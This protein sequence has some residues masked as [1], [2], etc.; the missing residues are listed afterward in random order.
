[1]SGPVPVGA[2]GGLG[3]KAYRPRL[4]LESCWSELVT[5][6]SVSV[7]LGA[8]EEACHGQC[9]HR[10]SVPYTP[11]RFGGMSWTLG[12]LGRSLSG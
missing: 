12:F 3:S 11:D 2:V 4:F 7:T 9:R 8:T 1:M 10:G 6:Q 5:F